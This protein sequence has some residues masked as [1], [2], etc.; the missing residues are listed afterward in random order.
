MIEQIAAR[1]K[2]G[3]G[4]ELLSVCFADIAYLLRI[5]RAAKEV[6]RLQTSAGY[7][8]FHEHMDAALAELG[9]ALKGD[10]DK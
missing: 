6:H 7:L 2:A 3:Y 8:D 1:H 10:G 9:A 5:A 4:G